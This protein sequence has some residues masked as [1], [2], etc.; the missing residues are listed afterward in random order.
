MNKSEKL[1]VFYT[2]LD[3]NS[4]H[5]WAQKHLESPKLL[6]HALKESINQQNRLFRRFL[7]SSHGSLPFPRNNGALCSVLDACCTT[8]CILLYFS[9]RC[10]IIWFLPN[11]LFQSCCFSHLNWAWYLLKIWV[12]HSASFTSHSFSLSVMLLHVPWS[13]GK[14]GS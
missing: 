11:T 6:V 12:F 7:K 1:W 10:F 2:L 4:P 9:K 14:H 5:H 3:Y 8:F 13:Q